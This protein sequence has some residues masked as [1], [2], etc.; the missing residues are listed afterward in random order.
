MKKF[1]VAILALLYISTSTGAFVHVHYCMGEM[2]DWGF[3]YNKS[4]TCGKC[5]MEEV[6][7]S[8]NGC[9]KDEQKFIKNDTDQKTSKT[10]IQIT[11]VM[12]AALPVSFIEIPSNNFSSVIGETPHSRTPLRI[13]GV[14]VYIRNCVFLI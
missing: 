6:Q 10:I 11:P 13:N 14:A 3:G 12:A 1:F 5:G 4:S 8:D 2:A 9:C 7:G